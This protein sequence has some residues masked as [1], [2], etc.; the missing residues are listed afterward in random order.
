[1][2]KPVTN[3]TLKS[4]VYVVRKLRQTDDI[5]YLKCLA[6]KESLRKIQARNST[7]RLTS[8]QRKLL[9]SVDCLYNREEGVLWGP[10]KL[11]DGRV[12]VVCRC[13]KLDCKY[14]LTS[15]RR[16]E[17]KES[18]EKEIAL[19]QELRQQGSMTKEIHGEAIDRTESKDV[20]A[21]SATSEPPKGTEPT[22]IPEP[23][24]GMESTTTTEPLKGTE[25]TTTTEPLKGTESTTTTEPLKGTESTTTPEP[26]KGTEST[27]TT[28]P[29][30]GTEPTTTPEPPKGAESQ[31]SP[32]HQ[33]EPE[34][35]TKPDL[36]KGQ[37]PLITGD[38]SDEQKAVITADHRKRIL[39]NAGPGTGKTW[40]LIERIKEFLNNEEVEPENIVVL[41]FSRAA[42]RVI[43]ERLKLA[44]KNR[45]INARWRSIDIRTF[46]SFATWLLANLRDAEDDELKE[47][48]PDDDDFENLNY[49]QRILRAKAIFD[50][51]KYKILAD[52]W[53]H[54]IVDEVQDLVGPRAELVL[55]ML[56][57]LPDSCG[58][59]LLGD[60]CQA[61]YDYMSEDDNNVISSSVFRKKLLENHSNISQVELTHNYRQNDSLTAFANPYR[62]AILEQ[63]ADIEAN[64]AEAV[65]QKIASAFWDMDNLDRD[66]FEK[67]YAGKKTGILTRTNAQ[68]LLIAQK[69]LGKNIKH[70]LRSPNTNVPLASWIYQVLTQLS[71]AAIA[72]QESFIAMFSKLYPNQA[73]N[74]Q[75]YWDAVIST[76]DDN[77]LTAYS[78]ENLLKGILYKA[79]DM[80]LF[81][82]PEDADCNIFV[83]NVHRSKGLEYDNVVVLS[84]LL[85]NGVEEKNHLEHKIA[86][87]AITRAKDEITK[88]SMPEKYIYIFKDD[89]RRCFEQGLY[90]FG[91]IYLA[92]FEIQT[93]DINPFMYAVNKKRQEYIENS[94]HIGD[95]MELKKLGGPD[96]ENPLYELKDYDEVVIGQTTADFA[97]AVRTAIT[98]MYKGKFKNKYFTRTFSDIYVVGKTTHIS[99][100]CPELEGAHKYGD[101]YVWQGLRLG[102]FAST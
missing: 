67:Y 60:S 20:P 94:I 61:I 2:S 17:T 26:L 45:T 30:K 6:D 96:E 24:E 102:G 91:K 49:E 7:Y 62:H 28:E 32:E 54:V 12:K 29:L 13:T 18:I 36:P 52:S 85:T 92:N 69:L 15:C 50:N 42:V 87:V 80:L 35:Q 38:S 10:Y 23:P 41:C 93:G 98:R 34:P 73:E 5:D 33:K 48:L 37:E 1:M 58:F 39:V 56:N 79:K 44:D 40:T 100:N 31:T 75:A 88:I 90:S 25:F 8:Y 14:L 99:A 95:Q 46:D 63:N 81:Q 59:T 66:S 16:Y 76:Q 57:D 3:I 43:T 55:A 89:S 53:Q 71:T 68:A 21:I 84:D 27:T 11:P 22:T 77:T 19:R 78:V 70:L 97:T 4:N 64:E 74:A 65:N 101:Y 9:D 72:T 47:L 83:S 82:E 51:D 86:Y